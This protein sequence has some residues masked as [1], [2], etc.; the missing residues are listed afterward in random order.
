MRLVIIYDPKSSKL[1]KNAYS[2]IYRDMWQ[3][4]ID[5]FDDVIHITEETDM[6]FVETDVIIIYDLHSSHHLKLPN[7]ETHKAVKYTYYNDPWQVTN[8][9]KYWFNQDEEFYKLGAGKRV[10]RTLERGIDYIIC[11]SKSGFWQNIAPHLGKLTEKMFVWFPLSVNIDRFNFPS[12]L[13]ERIPKVL[14][15]GHRYV[16]LAGFRPYEFRRWAYKQDCTENIEHVLLEPSTP[17]GE[18]YPGFIAGYAGACAFTDQVITP[19]YS[20][21]PAA[22]CVCFVQMHY[23]C[24]EMGFIDGEN[25]IAVTKGNYKKKMND[26]K[27]HIEE[28]QGMANAGRSLIAEKWTSRNFADFIYNH[29]KE[30]LNVDT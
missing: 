5:R 13:T 21:I 10:K 28:Y 12:P 26:F 14:L 16:G 30:N 1:I 19:K 9:G 27:A 7:I 6:S 24:K 23:D 17:S 15:N 2:L 4:L 8:R 20:E 29:A 22:S 25:C 11:H 3:A 18:Q